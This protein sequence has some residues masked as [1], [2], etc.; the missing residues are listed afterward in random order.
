MIRV[1]S[2][3]RQFASK[4]RLEV[5]EGV[6]WE[7]ECLEQLDLPT[8]FREPLTAGPLVTYISSTG[9]TASEV[10]KNCARGLVSPTEEAR[11]L[12]YPSAASKR[13]TDVE[14]WLWR[15]GFVR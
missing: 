12:G 3:V 10:R 14:G 7:P 8:W 6:C 11:L 15:C 2:F 4:L 9:L 5:D 13:N 1:I